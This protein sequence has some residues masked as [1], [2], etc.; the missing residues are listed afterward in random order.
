MSS[1]HHVEQFAHIYAK[2]LLD[3]KVDYQLVA[4]LGKF[5]TEANIPPKYIYTTMVD[6]VPKDMVEWMGGFN[7]HFSNGSYGAYMESEEE[8][9]HYMSAMVGC[10]LRNYKTAALFTTQA[11]LK[12]LKKN[13]VFDQ[14]LIVVPNF[15]I[16]K[17]VGG[18][19]ATWEVTALVG[20]I[21]E[22]FSSSKLTIIGVKSI[23]SLRDTY[24]DILAGHV[25]TY[26]DLLG[27]C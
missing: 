1:V 3:P 12:G 18:D 8:I 4:N 23:K 9:M 26:F 17:A 11:V 20:W 15:Q 22:R 14:D 2:K 13:E 10:A 7:E 19:I 25:T 16:Q 5:A 24:G 21:L 27:G 6:E